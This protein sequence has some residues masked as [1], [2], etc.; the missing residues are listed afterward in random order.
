MRRG[1]TAPPSS[2]ILRPV[3][4]PAAQARDADTRGARL[5]LV[6]ER[7]P[8]AARRSRRAASSRPRRSTSASSRA[9]VL[10]D[11]PGQ[12]AAAVILSVPV[13]LRL[14]RPPATLH[15]WRAG[16]VGERLQS[17]RASAS[18]ACRSSS[19]TW[20]PSTTSTLEAPTASSS[21]WSGRRA[22][23]KTTALRVLAG[24]EGA[25]AGRDLDRRPGRDAAAAAEPRHRDGLP[26]LRALS[27]DDGRRRT[28]ASRSRTSGM[29]RAVIEQ[30][31]RDAA[32]RS[33]SAAPPAQA[34][35]L[36][37]GQRQRVAL[38]RAIVREPAVFLM[39]EPLSNL[40]ASLRVQMRGEIK[41]LQRDLGMTTVYRHARPGRGDD[42]GRPHRDHARPAGSSRSARRR[43]STA[44]P[45]NRFVAGFVGSPGDELSAELR[46]RTPSRAAS[47][48]RAEASQLADRARWPRGCPPRSIVGVTARGRGASVR[49]AAT[50]SA[51]SPAKSRT[52]RI[53][54]ASGLPAIDDR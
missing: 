10:V 7:V 48:S 32:E 39:D 36:S 45:R 24:L 30:R 53:S 29:K 25:S 21:C 15:P 19:A 51:R 27:A 52:W 3:L 50:S 13:L 47:C 31:V 41:R 40:D 8:A 22:R 28:W 18:R 46:R 6:V 9:S 1:S 42:H 26:G 35:Q 5:R 4:L 38:G 12:A 43:R 11:I 17:W 37:G 44:S 34:G 54:A 2:A 20:S 33:A 23:G 16:R 14:R 49:R